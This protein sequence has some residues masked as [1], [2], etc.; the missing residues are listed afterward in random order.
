MIPFLLSLFFV[1]L[2]LL[3]L[4][5]LMV[6]PKPSGATR[7]VLLVGLAILVG[8]GVVLDLARLL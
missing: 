2:V 8:V 6:L 4:L 1:R 3:A 7:Q 5:L